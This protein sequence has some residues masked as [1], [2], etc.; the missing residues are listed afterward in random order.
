MDLEEPDD[1]SHRHMH[2]NYLL[3]IDDLY[4]FL[5]DDPP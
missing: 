2:R 1:Q 5:E 4:L 3:F